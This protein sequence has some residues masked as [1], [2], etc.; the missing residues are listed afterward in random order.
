MAF[1]K[2]ISTLPPD[3][4]TLEDTGE[5]KYG[6]ATTILSP[7]PLWKTGLRW[8]LLI[9]VSAA[10]S[11]CMDSQGIPAAYML[12]AIISAIVFRVLNQPMDLP[13]PMFLAAQGVLGAM[14]ASAIPV[15]IFGQL[16]ARWP[17]FLGGICSVLF[18]S[19]ALG[20]FLARRHLLPGTT[21]IWGTSPGA[22]PAMII[23]AEEFGADVRLVALMQ[24]IRVV[25]VALAAILVA[26]YSSGGE[27]D[28][29][30][31]QHS[32]S[33]DVGNY[34]QFFFTSAMVA[35]G[36]VGG[37]YL[38]IGAGPLLLT[39]GLGMLCGDTGIIDIT[40]PQPLL[41]ITYF[42]IGWNIGFRF[43][44][45]A[46]KYALRLL[47]RMLL[48]IILLIVS[49]ALLSRLLVIFL[50]IDPLT[51]YLALSPGGADSVA[52]IAAS[53]HADMSF[54]MAMQTGRLI[55]VMISGPSIARWMASRQNRMQA[56]RSTETL[57]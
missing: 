12:G 53:G 19:N 20:M 47:P 6:M 56:A 34:T 3:R 21:A 28:H 2:G 5:H 18:L 48:S 33:W 41:R 40:L 32:M 1:S 7:T 23:M 15:A 27:V 14:I 16:M 9:A 13:K 30:P 45:Q 37:K 43:T 26:H 25:L 55:L 57:I 11:L 35:L 52:I 50:G 44:R 31:I 51:A 17:L 38:K 54:V 46:L 24:Y 22:A 42:F 4:L 36:V 8:G 29:V 10:L 39:L 49:C